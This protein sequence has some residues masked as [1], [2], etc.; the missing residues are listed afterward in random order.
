MRSGLLRITVLLSFSMLLVSFTI[1]PSPFSYS[2][3]LAADTSY[4]SFV[5]AIDHKGKTIISSNELISF[6]SG[7]DNDQYRADTISRHCYLYLETVVKRLPGDS[8]KRLPLN[9]SIVIDRSGSMK[10]EKID[11]AIEAANNIVDKLNA[12]DIVSIVAYG[13]DVDV[14]QP[15]IAAI[16]K[17]KIKEKIS[18]IMPRG[19]TNLWG[20]CETGYYQV[21]EHAKPGYINHVFLISDGLAN[22][23]VTSSKSIESNVQRFKDDEGI[24]LSSFG[25]GLDFNEIL[26]SEMAETGSGNYYF[27]EEPGKIKGMLETELNS[28]LHV[29]A[30]EAVLTLYMPAGVRPNKMVSLTYTVNGQ[31]IKIKLRDLNEGAVKRVLMDLKLADSVRSSLPFRS[32]LT[33]TDAQ[34]GQKRQLENNNLIQPAAHKE[35]LGSF[36]REVVGQVLLHAAGENLEA[37]M[38]E[39]DKDD[40]EKAGKMLEQNLRLLENHRSYISESKSLQQIENASSQYGQY[41]PAMRSMNRDSLRLIQK[42]SRTALFNIRNG[43]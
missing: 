13:D 28:V 42:T 16:K 14:V 21:L 33:Y 6:S 17:E 29:A 30:R 41:M 38:A 35:Y 12:T 32:V 1:S 34:S 25:V 31:M 26:L 10:G 9:I 8:V 3:L 23:G 39:V 2:L 22:A 24:T 15:A 19:G 20:G 27:I 40:Y 4:P 36:N 5:N 11:H 43:K 7:M 18:Q 37:V